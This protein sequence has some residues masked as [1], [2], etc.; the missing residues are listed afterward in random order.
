V[1]GD[2][3]R[4]REWPGR[5]QFEGNR[6]DTGWTVYEM[7]SAGAARMRIIKMTKVELDKLFFEDNEEIETRYA[8]AVAGLYAKVVAKIKNS[9]DPP[10]DRYEDPANKFVCEEIRYHEEKRWNFEP[11]PKFLQRIQELAGDKSIIQLEIT[12]E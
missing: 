11:H 4:D 9:G 10:E 8:A 3:V 5:Q 1:C 2:F 12:E 6:N 7:P